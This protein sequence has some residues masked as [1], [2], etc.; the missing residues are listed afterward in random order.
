MCNWGGEEEVEKE[1]EK[2]FEDIFG[3]NYQDR[4]DS[5]KINP[6]SQSQLIF[7]KATKSYKMGKGKSSQQK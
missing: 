2:K 3:E 5:S 7:D 4:I 1:A 6:Q